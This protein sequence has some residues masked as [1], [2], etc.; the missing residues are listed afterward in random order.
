MKQSKRSKLVLGSEILPTFN[1]LFDMVDH[2]LR[3]LYADAR[4][5]TLSHD[6][7][8]VLVICSLLKDALV[9]FDSEG[10]GI[11]IDCSYTTDIVHFDY[12]FKINYILI[13]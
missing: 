8:S 12:L 13:H 7:W 9:N 11:T 5:G 10:V 4:I 2:D 6:F 3:L 1:H